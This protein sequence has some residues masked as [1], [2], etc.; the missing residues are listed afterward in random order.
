MCSLCDL[1][2]L[3]RKIIDFLLFQLALPI[4]VVVALIGGILLLVSAGDPKKVEQGKSALTN[5]VIGIIIAFAAW[6]LINTVL[7][8]LAFKVPFTSGAL[9]WNE[10]PVC[11][12]PIQAPALGGG[13]GEGD[14]W[15]CVDTNKLDLTGSCSKV[16]SDACASMG[17]TPW[18]NRPANCALLEGYCKNDPTGAFGTCNPNANCQ[19]CVAAGGECTETAPAGC[20]GKCAPVGSGPCSVSSLS[21]GCMGGNA[22]NAS[23]ICNGESGGS[24]VIGSKADKTISPCPAGIVGAPDSSRCS[25][26]WGLFQINIAANDLGGLGCPSAFK[27]TGGAYKI[28]NPSLFVQCVH[29]AQKESVNIA[30]ACQMSA[31]G[32][33]FSKDWQIISSSCGIP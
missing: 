3:V 12:A 24:S 32:S 17:G 30:K 31:N 27:K 18:Q 33:N 29:E 22:A 28:V 19:Q 8:T 9:P 26:S 21:A 16:D 15:Y 23:Q 4:A 11:Q 14:K 6:L 20:T 25:F 13:P 2:V 10:I 7:T 5:A 1:Y